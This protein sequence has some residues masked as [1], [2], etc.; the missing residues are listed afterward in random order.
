MNK[1]TKVVL[2][3]ALGAAFGVMIGIAISPETL[4]C[5]LGIPIG[6]VA[7]YLG[8]DIRAVGRAIVSA[9]HAVIGWRPNWVILK[10]ALRGL[11][12][13]ELALISA[14]LSIA[15]A[16][17]VVV[18]P[19]F[20]DQSALFTLDT[21][22]DSV[23]F[24]TMLFLGGNG[25][26]IFYLLVEKK[27]VPESDDDLM[28]FRFIALL[29]FPPVAAIVF[30]GFLVLLLIGIIKAIPMAAKS[31]WHAGVLFFRFFRH[32]FKLIH[33]YERVIVT[34]DGTLGAAL[35]LLAFR[36]MLASSWGMSVSAL[37]GITVGAILGGAWGYLNYFIFKVRLG[38]AYASEPRQ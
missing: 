28:P 23:L 33:S 37:I 36:Y 21:L 15:I 38:W 4:W 9:W 1:G 14:L 27:L 18:R 32:V 35:G 5:L 22:V 29:M 31:C 16:G 3:C 12:W 19:L 13:R 6:A 26:G 24:F 25:V 2:V 20:P 30:V 34:V 8:W 10:L 17:A 11:L 7:L